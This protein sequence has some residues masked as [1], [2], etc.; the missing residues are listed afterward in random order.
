[1]GRAPRR[2]RGGG[3]DRDHEGPRGR[4]AFSTLVTMAVSAMLTALAVTL[5][6]GFFLLVE[7]NRPGPSEQKIVVIAR[8]AAVSTIGTHLQEEGVIRSASLFRVAKEIY[9]RNGLKAGEYEISAK[10]SMADVLRALASGKVLFHGVTIPEGAT[11]AAAIELVRANTVLTGD[12]PRPPP[13]GAI[14]PETYVVERGMTR[15]EVVAQMLAARER[16]LLDLWANRAQDLPFETPEEALTLASIVEKETGLA[17]E[18]PQVASVFINRLRKG[19]RLESDPT[20]IY[21]LTRGVPLG[22]GL[23]RSEI[24]QRTPYNT[25]QI[26]ALPPGPISNPGRAAIEAVLNPPQSNALFFVADGSGGHV[27]ADTYAEHARN[28]AKWREIERQR[29]ATAIVTPVGVG[30]R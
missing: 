22:R 26:P 20:I 28:V 6:L 9:G 2:W 19:M 8:G 7:A 1:M 16:L 25:Y 10:A 11:S 14:L 13:E 12:T 21:G 5:A 15:A 27:F 17:A 4:N 30:S 18:R 3:D 29:A 23:R 24:D